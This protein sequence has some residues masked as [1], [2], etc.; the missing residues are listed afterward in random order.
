MIIV[1]IGV[2]ASGK[3]TLGEALASALGWEFI[4]GDAFHPPENVAKMHQGEP[5]ND[6][7]RAPWLAALNRRIGEVEAA[8]KNAVLSCSALKKRYRDRLREGIREIRF[9]YLCGD[10][11]TIRAR[12]Q[13]R[14][15]HFMPGS[16]LDSQIATLEPPRDALLVPIEL[17]TGEQVAAVRREL[18]LE[19]HP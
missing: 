3:S 12:L 6:A 13:A 2:T 8:G 5:L 9:V 15:G 18:S 7:D 16:L 14:R 10:P 17:P 4:E 11:E 1:V 19:V